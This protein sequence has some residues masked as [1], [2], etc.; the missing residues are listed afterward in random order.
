[1]KVFD[2]SGIRFRYP[3]DWTL[4][5]EPFENGWTVSLYSPATAFLVVTFDRERDDP[6]E[7]A[8]GG[9]EAMRDMYPDLE[10]DAVLET[11]A[12]QPALGYDIDFFTLD[13]TNTC[14]IRALQAPEGC[15][16]L[17]SQCTDTELATNGTILKAI[18]A[19]L[20]VEEA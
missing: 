13:L 3:A 7:L 9:L 18:R 15:L 6:A 20:E 11:I 8:D 19:S 12:G 10:A 1:M 5:T 2:K 14:W 17:L 16:L 4:E